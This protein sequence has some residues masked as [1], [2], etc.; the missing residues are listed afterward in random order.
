[1]ID[2]IAQWTS[3]NGASFEAFSAMVALWSSDDA[4]W[5]SQT[6]T[7]LHREATGLVDRKV[8]AAPFRV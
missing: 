5:S 3:R 8:Q 7:R 1:M 6:M 2:R 4:Y